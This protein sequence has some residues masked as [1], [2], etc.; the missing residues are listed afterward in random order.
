ML[1]IHRE[2]SINVPNNKFRTVPNTVWI[3]SNSDI[4]N[5]K[6]MA[7]TWPHLVLEKYEKEF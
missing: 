7:L 5:S 1:I 6:N 2:F 4:N 3:Y